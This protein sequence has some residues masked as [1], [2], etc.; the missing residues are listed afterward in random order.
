M[1]QAPSASATAL[2]P[3]ARI[4]CPVDS[5]DFSARALRHAAALATWDHGQMRVL[6]VRPPLTA[7]TFW[8]G[9]HA[10]LPPDPPEAAD[11]ARDAL[12]RFVT[13]TT[14]RH[15]I[16][17]QIEIGSIVF[18]I[19]RA[20]REWP[21]DLIVMGTHGLSGWERLLLGSVT[22][23][24]LRQTPAPVLAIPRDADAVPERPFRTVL[25]AVDR[26]DTARRAL[27]YAMAITRRGGGRLVVVH[28]VEHIADEDPQFAHHFDVAECFRPL[29]PALREHYLRLIPEEAR[30]ACQAQVELRFG[31]ASREILDAAGTCGAELVVAGAAGASALFGSTAHEIVRGATVP[32]LVVPP[33]GS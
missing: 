28:V 31:K 9:P 15:D 6:S 30:T 7:M 10:L 18:E 14:N 33:V 12:R 11:A 24:V 23:R 1:G 4:L 20:A 13:D 17:I 8:A 29:E 5:S 25:C 2:R 19:L 32:V 26:S 16:E 27:D 21:A 3:F 22:E